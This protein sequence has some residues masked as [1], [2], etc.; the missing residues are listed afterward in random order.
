MLIT[1]LDPLLTHVLALWCRRNADAFYDILLRIGIVGKRTRARYSRGED[2][3]GL[4]RARPGCSELGFRVQG[5]GFNF[6]L[7]RAQRGPADVPFHFT[8]QQAGM[9]Y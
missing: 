8:I 6:S 2:Q 1:F 5:S 4:Q 9:Q 3:I 7:E